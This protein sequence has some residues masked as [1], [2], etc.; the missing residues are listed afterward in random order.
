MRD[1]RD[2]AQGSIPVK[3]R[4]GGW[5][6]DGRSSS[7]D[8]AFLLARCI[9]APTL[10]RA[11]LLAVQWD[12][13]PHDVMIA[14][15]WVSESNYV[16]E[17]AQHLGL[18]MAQAGDIAFPPVPRLFHQPASLRWRYDFVRYCATHPKAH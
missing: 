11:E 8:Y 16:R 13:A 6:V 12:V 17:L 18:P 15:G 3:T 7:G 4:E 9:D 5:P 1:G 2:K 14:L 10:E